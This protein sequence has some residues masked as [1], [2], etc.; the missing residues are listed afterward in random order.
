MELSFASIN[1]T[2]NRAPEKDFALQKIFRE[3]E[4]Q[5]ER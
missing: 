5:A 2:K 3:N 1:L 4:E